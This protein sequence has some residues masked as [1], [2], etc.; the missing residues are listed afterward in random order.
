MKNIFEM[1]NDNNKT[2]NILKNILTGLSIGI[3]NEY[4]IKCIDS[5]KII[6]KK[7]SDSIVEQ[8]IKNNGQTHQRII[9]TI[10]AMPN[11]ELNIFIN[12]K[13]PNRLHQ[14]I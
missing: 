1:L 3:N 9:Q 4:I 5:C 8:Y 13:Y 2:S 14:N 11:R 12:K 10:F 6:N 7:I